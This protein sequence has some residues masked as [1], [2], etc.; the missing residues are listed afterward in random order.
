M[1]D[2]VGAI[3]R[4]VRN[5]GN[6]FEVGGYPFHAALRPVRCFRH[7]LTYPPAFA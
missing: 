3:G 5:G 1:E 6:W 7:S 2:T 4:Y